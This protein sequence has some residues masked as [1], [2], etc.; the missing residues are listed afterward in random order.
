MTDQRTKEEW[1]ESA[2]ALKAERFEV[3]GAL[4]DLPKDAL[5]NKAEVSVRLDEYLGL[6]ATPA[7]KAKPKTAAAAP[8]VEAPKEGIVNV[9]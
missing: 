9:D 6:N 2:A 5:L 4:F 7:P 3:A 1:I 8:A